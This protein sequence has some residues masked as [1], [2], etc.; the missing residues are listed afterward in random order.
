MTQPCI[1]HWRISEPDGPTS[2]GWCLRCGANRL[3]Y[4][5]DPVTDKITSIKTENFYGFTRRREYAP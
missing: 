2:E 5:W 3:F 1:H 4:N